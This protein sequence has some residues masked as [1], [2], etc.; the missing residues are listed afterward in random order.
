MSK[1]CKIAE[2]ESFQQPALQIFQSTYH[3]TKSFVVG[4]KLMMFSV[5]RFMLH[6]KSRSNHYV[7]LQ[8]QVGIKKSGAVRHVAKDLGR[9]VGLL[10]ISNISHKITLSL[11]EKVV[12]DTV[13]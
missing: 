9:L 13:D 5:F 10:T 11:L 3:S 4:M 7:L 8:T 12:N 6:D 2:S 1:G